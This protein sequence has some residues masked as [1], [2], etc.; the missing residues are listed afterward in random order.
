MWNSNSSATKGLLDAVSK[1]LKGEELEE[2]KLDPVGQADADIDNDG[3]VDK[4][5]QYLHNRRKAIKKAMKKEEVDLDEIKEEDDFGKNFG[6][7]IAALV[8]GGKGAEYLKKKADQ[9]RQQN[10]DLDPGAAKKGLGIGVIDKEKANKKRMAREEVEIDE[11]STVNGITKKPGEKTWKSTSMSHA[12]AVKMHGKDNV[13]IGPRK[14]GLGKDDVQVHVEAK[15]LDDKNVDKALKHDCASHVEHAKWG[16]GK[17]IP[18]MHTI[19]EN[20]NGEYVVTHY[21][22]MFVGVDGPFIKENVAVEDLKIV[23]EMSHGHPRK[24]K[25][26]EDAKQMDANSPSRGS[27]RK[28]PESGV[29]TATNKSGYVKK[30]KDERQASEYA[31]TG[32]MSEQV[33]VETSGSDEPDHI[34]VQLR[35]VV[36][37][38]ANH[39]GVQFKSGTTKVHPNTARLALNRYNAA[40]PAEKEQ[41][42]RHMAHS[43]QALKHIASGGSMEDSPFKPAAK[44]GISLG[45]L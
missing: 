1:V 45:K 18:E 10:K 31:K 25:V 44:K 36:S 7:R 34:A 37:V 38:G 28:D 8:K 3:D 9:T 16:P 21:D 17:C 41:L 32:G 6:K 13:R 23:S 2:K 43:P 22:V 35:K 27:V 42:Q 4:S 29:F 15:D 24:K 11:A 19:E 39:P 40:K 33:V 30:F 20:S 14:T 12:D 5:D 26:S